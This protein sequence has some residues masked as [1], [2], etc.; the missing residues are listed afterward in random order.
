MIFVLALIGVLLATALWIWWD[1]LILLLIGGPALELAR[2]A[3]WWPKP[4]G[5]CAFWMSGK[6]LGLAAW[7]SACAEARP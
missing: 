2:R 7:L 6:M 3:V 4:V 1:Y 5:K